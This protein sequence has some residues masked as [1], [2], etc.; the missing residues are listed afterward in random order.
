MNR[1]LPIALLLGTVGIAGTARAAGDA[2][3]GKAAASSCAMCHGPNG[4]GTKMG[5]RLAGMDAA[6][7]VQAMNDY[8]S[9]KRDNAMMKGQTSKLSAGDIANLAAYYVSPK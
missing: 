3:A 9:G 6:T 4:E 1:L 7:F 5:P 2:V 8:K